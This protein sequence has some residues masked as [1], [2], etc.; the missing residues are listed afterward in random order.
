VAR[1]DVIF[2]MTES[3]REAVLQGWP[4]AAAKTIRLDEA[5]DVSDPIGGT[6]DDYRA[7]ADQIEAALRQRL[8]EFNL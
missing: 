8:P 5:G 6:P 4:E 1:A 2:T 7:A 3:H